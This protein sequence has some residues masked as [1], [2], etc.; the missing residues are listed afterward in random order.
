MLAAQRHSRISQAVQGGGVVSTVELANSLGVSAET[1]RRDFAE[2]EGKGLLMRV[3][4]GATRTDHLSSEPPF[5]ERFGSAGEAKA[6]IGSLAAELLRPGQTVVI[7]VG[8]TATHVARALVGNF[9]GVV[10]TCSIQVANELSE[11]TGIEVHLS[12][13]RMRAG[14]LALSGPT[15]QSFFE[16][17]Y[18]DV[19]FLG[20]G[21]V[22][23]EAGL[24]DFYLDE[25]HVRRTIMR[26]SATHYVLADSTKLQRIAPYRVA[27]LER[28]DRL[29]TDQQPPEE[30]ERAITVSGGEVI[31][32]GLPPA[33][34]GHAGARERGNGTDEER[35]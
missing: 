25:C 2:L 28:V 15:T 1:I 10:L 3:R 29:I 9:S 7:D 34:T 21:G 20:S 16:D 18:A 11:A 22:H 17:V 12:S 14:D 13:G 19:A 30:L 31:R 27:P 8:T 32:P 24:T 35:T 23:A 5:V 4:G 26:N 6:V 33:E